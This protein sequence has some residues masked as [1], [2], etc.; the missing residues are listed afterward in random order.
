MKSVMVLLSSY[1]GER[2]IKGQIESILNQKDIDVHLM[3][4]DDGSTDSTIRIIEQYSSDKIVLIK[5]ENVGYIESFDYLIRNAP[6]ADFYAYSDQDDVWMEDKLIKAIEQLDE[7][8]PMLYAGNAYVT[9]ENLN[10]KNLFN[11]RE[12]NYFDHICK[13]LNSGAQGCTLVF[14]DVLKK[15]INEYCP[16]NVWPHDYWITTVCLFIGKVKYDPEPHMLYRQHSY[17]VTGG[18]LGVKNKIRKNINSLKRGFTNPWSKLAEDILHGYADLLE[19]KDKEI[20]S[21]LVTYKVSGKNKLKLL[22]NSEF[23]KE[24]WVKTGVLKLLIFFNRV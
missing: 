1:N 18:D 3:I 16:V 22:F 9:D 14:N 17:N 2:Y 7:G 19:E 5:G 6:R 4:R 8:R 11:E 23:K 10:K 13:I 15:R 21:E 20:L 24:T 12:K